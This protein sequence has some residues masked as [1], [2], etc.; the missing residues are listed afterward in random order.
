[1]YPKIPSIRVV[2]LASAVAPGLPLKIHRHQARRKAPTKLLLP[3]RRLTSN[4]PVR[5][6]FRYPAVDYFFRS[7]WSI[8]P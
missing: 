8:T 5:Y 3:A 7:E 2:D 4:S 6:L 1:M